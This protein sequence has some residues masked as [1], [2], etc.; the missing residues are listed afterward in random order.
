MNTEEPEVTTS[1]AIR[2]FE[3]EGTANNDA[4]VNLL[5]PRF[6]QNALEVVTNLQDSR[7]SIEDE[8]FKLRDMT[9]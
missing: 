9:S 1:L 2:S 8:G 4:D 7:N 3:K 5:P 6:D